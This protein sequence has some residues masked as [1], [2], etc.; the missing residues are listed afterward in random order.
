[1]DPQ[2]D[3]E[4]PG[5]AVRPVPLERREMLERTVH[6]VP[7]VLLVP[8]VWLV[9]VELSVCLGSVESAVLLVSLDHLE[10]PESKE[11][12]VA[13]ETV[14]PQAQLGPLG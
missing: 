3:R 2:D 6:Q 13:P 11:L 14:D 10:S 4:T 8:K 7:S 12:L 5:C 1:M 9:S